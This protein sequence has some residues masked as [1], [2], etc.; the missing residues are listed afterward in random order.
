MDHLKDVQ[1]PLGQGKDFD[2]KEQF[3]NTDT[4]QSA[5]L[6]LEDAC[7]AILG[8]NETVGVPTEAE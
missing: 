7:A 4:T 5:I 6:S 3:L 2:V 1:K 8:G